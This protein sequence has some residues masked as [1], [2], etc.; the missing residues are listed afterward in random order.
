MFLPIGFREN[1]DVPF[2]DCRACP[3]FLAHGP[4]P[5]SSKYTM[6]G[7]EFPFHLSAFS[8][9]IVAP[10]NQIFIKDLANLI[11]VKDSSKSF[12][13]LMTFVTGF[14]QPW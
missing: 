7:G 11:F 9:I 1:Y 12:F 5:L 3:H 2:R 4:L 8:F 14:E 10:F 6:G 13:V